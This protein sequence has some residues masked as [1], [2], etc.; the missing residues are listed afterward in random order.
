MDLAHRNTIPVASRLSK[1]AKP[2]FGPGSRK[3]E[4]LDGGGC[5]MCGNGP[6]S[7]IEEAVAGNAT[8]V[9]LP[10][11]YAKACRATWIAGTH[12]SP[13]RLQPGVEPAPGSRGNMEISQ[14]IEGNIAGFQRSRGGSLD[15]GLIFALPS[16]QNM[17]VHAFLNKLVFNLTAAS[18]PRGEKPA[19]TSNGAGPATQ[20]SEALR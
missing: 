14:E 18:R 11:F 4:E 13:A 19:W 8:R 5:G 1:G 9:S 15:R 20:V 7:G 2:F 17:R 6:G 10:P 12:R 16:R 3:Y